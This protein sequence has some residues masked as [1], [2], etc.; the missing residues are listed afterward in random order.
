MIFLIHGFSKLS[1]IHQLLGLV[2]G[3]FYVVAVLLY[4][5]ALKDEEVSRVV[6]LFG[7]APIFVTVLAAI[8]L[9]EIFTFLR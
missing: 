4:F 9:G 7:M 5:E 1:V 2:A 8:F 3:L 6:P